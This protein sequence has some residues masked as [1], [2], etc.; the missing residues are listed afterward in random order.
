[1]E[2]HLNPWGQTLS[3]QGIAGMVCQEKWLRS[4][5]C[6]WI[7][8]VHLWNAKT[9]SQGSWKPSSFL[10]VKNR[11]LLPR[12]RC[13]RLQT[14]LQAAWLWTGRRRRQLRAISS[15]RPGMRG[16][17]LRD[18][19]NSNEGFNKFDWITANLNFGDNVIWE[20]PSLC[21][22]ACCDEILTLCIF[23]VGLKIKTLQNTKKAA[24]LIYNFQSMTR[25]HQSKEP[26]TSRKGLPLQIS[27]LLTHSRSLC[28]GRNPK[29]E[30]KL[31][32]LCTTKTKNPQDP[33]P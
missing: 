32:H 21:T 17:P 29:F 23:P 14:A 25:K 24:C 33:S 31:Q 22:G 20:S 3:L 1:M 18:N 6:H 15:G 16:S 30:I 7:F 5:T 2:T 11:S 9:K 26:I 28:K 10:R 8:P 27:S 13:Q 19:S 12:S 4:R